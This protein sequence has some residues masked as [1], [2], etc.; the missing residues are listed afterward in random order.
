MFG[1][2]AACA[3]AKFITNDVTLDEVLPYFL[4]EAP[5]YTHLKQFYNG[6]YNA[7][8]AYAFKN[9]VFS[10]WSAYD[11]SHVSCDIAFDYWIKMGRREFT[12]P[13]RYTMYFVKGNNGWRVANLLVR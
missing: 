12:Y 2:Q 10:D 9:V 7:H 6:W 1:E 4:P 13:S 5:Y 3:Y 11:E 8:D